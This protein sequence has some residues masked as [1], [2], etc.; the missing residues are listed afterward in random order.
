MYIILFVSIYQGANRWSYDTD[1]L[2]AGNTWRDELKT[3]Q[4]N[5]LLYNMLILAPL[6][7]YY[8]YMDAKR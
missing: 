8:S 4:R 1:S 2:E 6:K 7:W 5:H 3:N